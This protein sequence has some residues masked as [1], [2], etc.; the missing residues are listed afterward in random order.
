M[1]ITN[2]I[3]LVMLGFLTLLSPTLASP[4]TT[5]IGLVQDDIVGLINNTGHINNTDHVNHTT[6]HTVDHTDSEY[7]DSDQVFLNIM[8]KRSF[9]DQVLVKYGLKCK[10]GLAN[11]KTPFP[12]IDGD[13]WQQDGI[14][15]QCATLF[16]C[17]GLV[18][19]NKIIKQARSRTRPVA[20]SGWDWCN[21][22]CYCRAIDEPV[23]HYRYNFGCVDG[24]GPGWVQG[25][26]GYYKRDEDSPI[27]I[28]DG[29][30]MS[31]SRG[32]VR[33]KK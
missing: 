8:E 1:K 27:D 32:P 21:T 14:E 33:K 12:A 2:F 5:A 15:R 10:D 19:G 4:L 6:N 13:V 7:T 28:G 26:V 3:G 29:F 22:N 20:R 25:G 17:D 31:E 11:S 23:R 24:K 18:G 30:K 16:D 9:L